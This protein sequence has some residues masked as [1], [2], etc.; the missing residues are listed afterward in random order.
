MKYRLHGKENR[1]SIGTYP[2]IGLKE[3]R[4][5]TDPP[6]LNLVPMAQPEPVASA[7][8]ILQHR[9]ALHFKAKCPNI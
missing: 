5:K 9:R 4:D 1:F 6:H 2:D 7:R 8:I 3:A